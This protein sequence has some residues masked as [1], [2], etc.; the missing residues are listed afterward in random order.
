MLALG[1]AW[2]GWLLASCLGREEDAAVRQLA[3]EMSADLEMVAPAQAGSGPA[4]LQSFME[5]S[6]RGLVR[7]DPEYDDEQRLT[8]VW[9]MDLTPLPITHQDVMAYAGG[10]GKARGFLKRVG[11]PEAL[12]DRMTSWDCEQMA[13]FLAIYGLAFRRLP[14]AQRAS[15][16]Y[17]ERLPGLEFED[18]PAGMEWRLGRRYALT[19]S[20]ARGE[21][22]GTEWSWPSHAQARDI[23]AL[24]PR[25][26][27]RHGL[28]LWR[29]ASKSMRKQDL[30]VTG[31]AMAE[32]VER[33]YPHRSKDG[34]ILFFPKGR[35][36]ARCPRET[37]GLIR[38][39]RGPWRIFSEE[40]DRARGG[41][42]AAPLAPLSPY[43]AEELVEVVSAMAA[44]SLAQDGEV[45]DGPFAAGPAEPA[46]PKLFREIPAAKSGLR[47][48]ERVQVRG[49]PIEKSRGGMAVF[50]YDNDGLADVFFCASDQT[51]IYR[52]RGSFRFEDA[53]SRAGLSGVFCRAGA[54]SAD[55]DNDG[56]PDLAVLHDRKGADRLLRNERGR[57]RDVTASVGLSTGPAQTSSAVW[58]DF[59]RD[60]KLDLFLA[61]YGDMQFKSSEPA[62]GDAKNGLPNRLYRQQGG[63]FEDVTVKAG[64]ADTGWALQAAAFDYDD[65][66]W[67]DLLVSNDFGRAML[68]RNMRD[69][70]F[71][72]VTKEAGIDSLGNGMGISVS[73]FDRDGR[74]DFYLTYVGYHRP[75]VSYLFPEAH[76]L[77]RSVAVDS[78]YRQR[79]ALYR[80]L[81]DGVFQDVTDSMIEETPTGWGWDA[82]F[83]DADNSGYDDIFLTNGWWPFLFYNEEANVLWRWDP[84]S[85]RYRDI[86]ETSGLDFPGNSRIGAWADLDRDG[87]LDMVVSGFH[88]P[89]LFAGDCPKSHHWLEVR[90]EGVRSNRDGIGA[91]VTVAA[92]DLR[93]TAEMGPQGGGFQNTLP[94]LL[95]FG[96]GKRA[97]AD[98]I[99]VRWPSG[100]RQAL[101]PAR[102]DRRIVIKESP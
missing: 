35:A 9:T 28:R 3:A 30:W 61:E 97:Q 43:A 12:V 37:A 18:D 42:E 46:Q 20:R 31:A 29:S 69:G 88:A 51:S 36:P 44:A 76:P 101:G 52:N 98:S 79:N 7:L 60:G 68:Y 85:R 87:C 14:S 34:E 21:G 32:A 27:E 102:A 80:N 15:L 8:R 100:V 83:L 73:D 75:R 77:I 23:A 45:W 90:L 55:Y 71:R 33:A 54:S 93:Q 47:L 5:W 72:D 64:L 91:R 92:G 57:F 40:L 24:W 16:L 95:H 99:E 63:R 66:G 26:F 19:Q 82:S 81:G 2:G 58:L 74:L 39:S 25:L 56:W 22:R 59:D 13:R 84:A 4:D 48:A 50:D 11:T 41:A 1:A 89:R 65:D 17:G 10:A 78:A 49:N 67:P 86:S 94:R 70:A 62:L 38:F 96:L 53:V 6:Y